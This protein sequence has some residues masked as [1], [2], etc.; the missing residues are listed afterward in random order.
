VIIMH[1]HKYKLVDFSFTNNGICMLVRCEH[2][3]CGKEVHS[4]E[5][6]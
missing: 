2:P 1:E 5:H 6:D 3:N 4:I